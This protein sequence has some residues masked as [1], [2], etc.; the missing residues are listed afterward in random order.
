MKTQERKVLSS[1]HA[2]IVINLDATVN[3]IVS[4][5]CSD[6]AMFQILN[7]GRDSMRLPEMVVLP[8]GPMLHEDPTEA[9]STPS[10]SS[11]LSY[12]GRSMSVD[13]TTTAAS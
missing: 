10:L 2:L 9:S 13:R 7:L 1:S 5:D 8:C 3:K 11:L 4:L 6:G 12:D